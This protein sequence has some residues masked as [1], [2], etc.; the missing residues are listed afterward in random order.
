MWACV[1][2]RRPHPRRGRRRRG[3]GGGGGAAAC[4]SLWWVRG[5]GA[6]RGGGRIAD[7]MLVR[8]PLARAQRRFTMRPLDSSAAVAA[9]LLQTFSKYVPDSSCT[10]WLI[11]C[12]V[13]SDRLVQSLEKGKTVICSAVAVHTALAE[14]PP[15][16]CRHVFWAKV[17]DWQPCVHAEL[18]HCFCS[19]VPDGPGGT[20]ALVGPGGGVGIGPGGGVGTPFS[21][22]D[23]VWYWPMEHWPVPF[24]TRM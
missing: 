14:P 11:G 15:C 7:A 4:V 17:C 21:T 18:V 12:S 22:I 13:V 6:G 23:V 10:H 1:V 2:G 16:S 20:G 19:N 24:S 9:P 3:C 8:A 5:R